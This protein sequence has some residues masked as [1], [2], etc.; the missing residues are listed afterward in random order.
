M[1]SKILKGLAIAAGTGLVIGFGG[2]RRRA[3]PMNGSSH[4]NLTAELEPRLEMQ[5]DHIE[6][7]QRQL[8]ETRQ[9]VAA[10]ATMVELR[11]AEITREI[12]AILESM[13]GP[14]VENLRASLRAEMLES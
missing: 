8:N 1:A 10:E 11:F 9:R 4:N 13:L 2:R 7:L 6:N 12:P 5:A 3:T 14:H